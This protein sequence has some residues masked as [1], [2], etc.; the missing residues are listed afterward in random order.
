MTL[1]AFRKRVRPDDPRDVAPVNAWLLYGGED[2][3]P[4]SAEL[5]ESREADRRG[6][7][8]FR[9]TAKKQVQVGDLV[10]LYFTDPRK[11]I[12]F[13]ARAT[14]D[15]YFEN[16]GDTGQ[17]WKGAQWWTTLTPPIQ[18]E[19]IPL[20]RLRA[21]AGNMVMLGGAGHYVRPDHAD[22]L[23][24]L[25]RPVR[26]RDTA[27]L[28]KVLRPVVGRA[29][30]PDPKRMDFATWKQIAAGSLT[31]ESEVERHIVEPLLR[32][33]GSGGEG[34]LTHQHRY[35]IGR[36]TA[37]YALLGSGGP[38]AAVEAKVRINKRA[39]EPWASSKDFQQA[40]G[41]GQSLECPALLI[42]AVDL[43]VIVPGASEPA[44]SVSRQFA[45]EE[46]LADLRKALGL[47]AAAAVPAPRVSADNVPERARKAAASP[48]V[49]VP[50]GAREALPGS[51][52]LLTW[53]PAHFDGAAWFDAQRRRYL[54]GL[55]IQ[56]DRWSTGNR[57]QG[58]EYGDRVYILRQGAAPRGIVASGRV[59]NKDGIY[60]DRSWRAEAHGLVGYVDIAWD[61]IAPLDEPLDIEVLREATGSLVSWR[62]QSG[63]VL[64]APEAYA[65]I[66]RLWQ[67][68][69][70]ATRQH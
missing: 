67:A 46:D 58:M 37:D 8:D 39:L 68:H 9:W 47:W 56:D 16:I 12:H 23:A 38:L 28:T 59:R 40:A 42:D 66:E 44:L 14:E 32:Y 62:V 29:D 55:T 11:E 63:G 35:A 26:K 50:S 4:T 64:V 22:A 17:S 65:S 10:F 57:R 51:A 2:S 52:F 45:T 41:Y 43:H 60:L 6:V 13:V 48:R 69:L 18:I 34:A 3:F 7:F 19:P 21:I 25:V 24:E 49:S 20:A 33:L 30:L 1:T 31:L 54:Q 5:K 27:A 61:A 15:A 70:H 53:N 36:K